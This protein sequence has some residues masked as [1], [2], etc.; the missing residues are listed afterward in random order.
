VL[1]T[2]LTLLLLAMSA[3]GAQADPISIGAAIGAWYASIGVVGQALVQIGVSLAISAA[4]YGLQSLLLGSGKQQEIAK[5]Q[6]Q[7]V[8]LPERNGL[9]QQRVI[10]GTRVVSGGVFFERTV[11]DS[12]SAQPDLYVY[13]VAVSI[14]V[15]EELVS[16]IINGVECELSGD[17]AAGNAV[18]AT[19]PWDDGNFTY[20]TVSFRPGTSTQARDPLITAN[21]PSPPADFLPDDA[22]RSTKWTEFR[23]RG[24][25]TVVME[26][27]FGA[28]ADHHTELWGSGGIPDIKFKIRGRHIYDPRDYAQ[29]AADSSTWEWSDVAALVEADWLGLDMGFGIATGE[30]DWTGDIAA[31]AR[32]DARV[33]PT[34]DGSERRG[35]VNAEVF[36]TEANIDVLEAMKLQNRAIIGKS[37]G[38]YWVRSDRPAE[39]VATIH[40]G[41]LV[42]EFAYQN[43]PDTRSIMNRAEVQFSPES[44]FNESAETVYEDAALIVADGQEY[45]QR[46]TL[47]YCDSPAAAQRLG[48]S[49]LQANRVGRTITGKFDIA[50]LVAAGKPEQLLEAGDTVRVELDAPYDGV[51]G[52]YRV[53]GLEIGGDCTVTLSL[54]GTDEDIIG[55]WSTT[56]ETA[57]EA[58]A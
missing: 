20:F 16:V 54:S 7:G 8:Q 36:S 18:P 31:S 44:R 38:L 42:G 27:Q 6:V 2:V 47:P 26:M 57:F 58:A 4:A 22:A 1:R 23:Q 43:E 5:G 9:L 21:W 11:A 19:A 55:G 32:F 25:A 45:E 34:L 41:L 17:P 52:L 53:N 46:L 50:C 33:I 13:G 37:F 51:N 10:Y 56:L 15:C 39:P 48:Y 28:D 35:R 40:Q 49:L 24:V 3:T 30:L 12:G 14:G 29:L